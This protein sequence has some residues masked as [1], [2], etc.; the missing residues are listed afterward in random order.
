MFCI[1]CGSKIDDTSTFC[2]V[3]G[4]VLSVNNDGNQPGSRSRTTVLGD[5]SGQDY[6]QG[7]T[8]L[9]DS[10]EPD[11]G[12]G[13]FVLWDEPQ[14][15]QRGN[16]SSLGGEHSDASQA[17]PVPPVRQPASGGF[18]QSAT[19][20]FG[21]PA[22]GGFG[23]P[24]SG[25]FGQPASG[26]FGQSATGG[27][28]LPAS[29]GF[30]QSATGGFGQPASGGFGQS[31]TGGFGQPASGGFGQSATGGFGQPAS[32][33]FGQSAAQQPSP[34]S[35]NQP[36]SY[37]F[38]PQP[39]PSAGQN[40]KSGGKWRIIGAVLGGLVL[41]AGIV[42]GVFFFTGKDNTEPVIKKRDKTGVL[43]K[44]SCEI[45]DASFDYIIAYNED[46]QYGVYDTDGKVAVEFEYDIINFIDLEKYPDLFMVKKDNRC[47]LI[48]GTGQPVIGVKYNGIGYYKKY[49]TIYTIDI[50]KRELV[51]FKTDGTKM[52]TFSY[53]NPDS[54]FWINGKRMVDYALYGNNVISVEENDIILFGMISSEKF[55]VYDDGKLKIVDVKDGK[56]HKMFDARRIE[57]FVENPDKEKCYY[58]VFEKDGDILIID[59]N[60][61]TVSE[62]EILT[63]GGKMLKQV[64]PE[65]D[66]QVLKYM[67]L[68]DD[69]LCVIQHL[70]GNDISNEKNYYELYNLRTEKRI[71]ENSY[72]TINSRERFIQLY[73]ERPMYF[74]VT[75]HHFDGE[76]LFEA[77]GRK[78]SDYWKFEIKDDTGEYEVL[79]QNMYSSIGKNGLL[80][81]RNEDGQGQ[82]VYQPF[83]GERKVL[84]TKGGV[85]CFESEQ[86]IWWSLVAF[87]KVTPLYGQKYFS[88]T[89]VYFV[90]EDP[91]QE[92]YR[93]FN[94]EGELIDEMTFKEEIETI[95]VINDGFY[96]K[97][98]DKLYWYNRKK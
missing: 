71:A 34:D 77:K 86:D 87:P 83:E 5:N 91:D 31:A 30:G 19:G 43:F 66:D 68:N 81:L 38:Y 40:K 72:C 44:T 6:R 92:T 85:Q 51:F 76:Q 15:E 46:H 36:A 28:G 80:L 7:T 20:G 53:Q 18:G 42:L 32:G 45:W 90:K 49:D 4:A 78:T 2:P 35:L 23:Q 56:L 70:Y 29:G 33:G 63:S 62:A 73:G 97:S 60:G 1:I 11:Y 94:D 8:V 89:S 57:L 59:H 14:R 52:G 54:M 50:I 39:V 64:V 74:S 41:V 10:P 96:L 47:G 65:N 27:F 26:G 55:C 22:S 25:G 61:D 9:G 75:I 13:T 93:V 69:G 82:F 16:T 21:Q 12:R 37:G 79:G 95:V 88:D 84:S 98:G 17:P 58:T 24:A 67:L 48:N 3:C